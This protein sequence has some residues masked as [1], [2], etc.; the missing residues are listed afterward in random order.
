[1]GNRGKGEQGILRTESSLGYRRLKKKSMDHVQNF[2]NF[3][4]ISQQVQ[5]ED[6]ER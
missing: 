2:Q 4:I 5:V 3:S 6:D 1:M